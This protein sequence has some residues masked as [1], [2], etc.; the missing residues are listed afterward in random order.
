[1]YEVKLSSQF[2]W[3]SSTIY[4]RTDVTEDVIITNIFNSLDSILSS[5]DWEKENTGK[6]C[7]GYEQI[8]EKDE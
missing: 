1:M 8:G 5:H 6:S 3:F 7:R 2:V 4:R